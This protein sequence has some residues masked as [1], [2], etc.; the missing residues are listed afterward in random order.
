MGEHNNHLNK[1]F[2]IDKTLAKAK[3]DL[4]LTEIKALAY[5]LS[6]IK[7]TSTTSNIIC[8]DTNLLSNAIGLKCD[9]NHTS[10][11]L[12]R[13]IS[14]LPTHSYITFEPDSGYPDGNFVKS[15]SFF[16][17]ETSITLNPDYL[18]LVS[19]LKKNY[20]ILFVDDILNFKS[21]RTAIF[22]LQLRLYSD[23]RKIN[24]HSFGIKSLKEILNIPKCG[25]GSYVRTDG[26]FDRYSF[27]KRVLNPLCDELSNCYL[28]QLK[29]TKYGQYYSKCKIN[30]SILGYKFC[31]II[32]DNSQKKINPYKKIDKNNT[33]KSKQKNYRS[34]GKRRNYILD[35]RN[36]NIDELEPILLLTR[37]SNS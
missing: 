9:K 17:N 6:H 5:V 10:N 13:S 24:E 34:N 7:F 15:V 31:W 1:I 12:K 3:S 11:H 2:A 8:V 27:E 28:I 16:G 29:T 18:P 19:C 20:I 30:G 25:P 4:N 22:Y 37:P 36:L 14:Q 35:E 23:T 26:H 21:K 33:Q 32:S